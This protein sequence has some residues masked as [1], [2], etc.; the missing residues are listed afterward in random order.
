MYPEFNEAREWVANEL[1][2]NKGDVNLFETTIRVLGG[3][4]SSYH[5]T[6]DDMFLQKAVS[7]RSFF[8][9]TPTLLLV[10]HSSCRIKFKIVDTSC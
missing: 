9:R 1:D 8:Y 3:L 10:H 6:K 4:L 7:H 2:F 5:L